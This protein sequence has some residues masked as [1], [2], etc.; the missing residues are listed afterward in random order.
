RLVAGVGQRA[1]A[2]GEGA[3]IRVPGPDP[4]GGVGVG[5]GEAPAV[6]A[7][8]EAGEARLARLGPDVGGGPGGIV[9]DLQTA[10]ALEGVGPPR[11]VVD[12]RAHRLAVLAVPDDV[13]AGVELTLDEVTHLAGEE[14]GE[15]LRL[16]AALPRGVGLEQ[17]GGAGQ[18]AGVGGEDAVGAR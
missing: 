10:G 14:C 1:G 15:V 17:R 3:R 11:A 12:R 6:A 8:E 5:L 16:L 7:V 9:D 18:A 13:D 4:G 2:R